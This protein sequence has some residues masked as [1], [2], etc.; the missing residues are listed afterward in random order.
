MM[1]KTNI[2][3]LVF[4]SRSV[5]VVAASTILE[6]ERDYDEQTLA[7]PMLQILYFLRGV[8]NIVLVRVKVQC[9]NM[10]FCFC[11]KQTRRLYHHQNHICA[12]Q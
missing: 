11:G 3:D 12:Q 10:S 6:G 4:T 1:Q 2:S 7:T 9:V 5:F 8:V